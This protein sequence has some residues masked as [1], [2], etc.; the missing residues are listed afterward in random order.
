MQNT[1]SDPVDV[2]PIVESKQCR[3]CLSNF[4]V[5]IEPGNRFSEMAARLSVFCSA[6]SK[7]VLAEGDKHLAT[8]R[9]KEREAVWIKVCPEQ[10]RNTDLGHPSLN[11]EFV[12][13]CQAWRY[14]SRKGLGLVS[15]SG[16]GKTRLLYSALRRAFDSGLWTHATSHTIFRRL[17]IEAS[18][19]EGE[20]RFAARNKLDMMTRVDVLL[21]DDLGKAPS[22]EAVDAEVEDL[23]EAR[24]SRGRLILWSS[25]GGADWL[26]GRFGPD[27][28]EPIVRR[29]AE[30]T[31]IVKAK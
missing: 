1:I 18:S 25:N 5:E 13:A 11:R 4:T 15:T 7:V 23:I 3:K 6:C 17:A 20:N 12:A 24:T 2:A 29:L 28:G 21:F 16:Q 30:F 9:A 22:T 19:G 8:E 31:Q 26:M 14:S 10:Y 27:R